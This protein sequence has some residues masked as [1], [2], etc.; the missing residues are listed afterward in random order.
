MKKLLVCLALLYASSIGAESPDVFILAPY[1]KNGEQ[2]INLEAIAAF[3]SLTL[4]KA[5]VDELEK[6]YPQF[7]F[8]CKPVKFYE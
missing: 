4:C 7:D 8:G 5:A 3:R 6:A 2:T 1:V